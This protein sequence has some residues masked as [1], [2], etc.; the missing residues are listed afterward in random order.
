MVAVDVGGT[1]TDAVAI[2]GEGGLRVAKVP[3]TPNDPSIGLAAAL[4]ELAA[5]GVIPAHV[6][7][8]S[9]GTTIATNAILTGRIGRVV[10]IATEGFRDILAYR[11]G[12]R[13]DIYSLT[14]E[15]PSELVPREDRLEV[16]ERLG[17]DG[18]VVTRLTKAEIARVVEEVAAREPEAVAIALLFS[19]LDDRH[20]QL[21]ADALRK[22]LPGVPVTLS[23]EIAREFREYPRTATAALNA[24]LRPLVGRYLLEARRRSAELGVTAPFIVMQS[25]GGCVPAERADREA[26]RLLLSGPAGGVTGL[27]AL[28]R[29]HDVDKLV[30]LDMGGTS[31]DVCLVSGS[32][33]PVVPTQVIDGHPVLSSS[34]HIETVGAGGGSI[35]YVDRAGRLLR[36]SA[37]R[38]RRPRAGLLRTRRDRGDRDRRAC[39]R[40]NA[41][42]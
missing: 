30:S 39:G 4:A 23:A 25:N 13:P 10:L 7:L 3:S 8:L 33:P 19:Y 29:R 41:R 18:S 40:R 15:K 16:R 20:E 11:G 24:G 6:R 9:H 22:R 37:E 35:A 27:L 34:V 28:G 36:R 17:G 38:G 26:H 14:P 12:S 32:A 31:L 5:D 2:G 21:L 1:F 42:V